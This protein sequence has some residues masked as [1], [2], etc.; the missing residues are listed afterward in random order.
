MNLRYLNMEKIKMPI[1]ITTAYVIL[2]V[3]TI[4]LDDSLR[5]PILLFSL[6]PIPVFWMVWR[7]LRDG[8]PSPFT[9]KEKFYDDHDY[10]RVE[11]KEASEEL[12]D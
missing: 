11:A 1:A 3:S 2:Y 10:M 9:F 6:S 8:T 7:V 4:H 5:L 12:V